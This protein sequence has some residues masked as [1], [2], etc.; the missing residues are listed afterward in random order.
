MW[1]VV[2]R[3]SQVRRA[4]PLLDRGSP[5]ARASF[6]LSAVP[7]TLCDAS[8]VLVDV[9]AAFERFVD[10]EAGALLGR[11]VRDL[12]H[13]TD[14]GEADDT[15]AALLAGDCDHAQDERVL[16]GPGGRPLPVLVSATALRAGRG[17]VLGAASIY[18]DLTL[19]RSLEQR[20]RQQE[21]F[22]LAM[23]RHASDL[24]LLLDLGGQVL[25]VSPTLTR[26]L[27]HAELD[28]LACSV[29]DFIHPDD[30]RAAQDAFRGTIVTGSPGTVTVRVRHAL[31][32]WRW[33]EGTITDLLHTSVGGVVCNLR[34]VTD[35]VRAEEALRASERRYRAMADHAD[36]GLWLTGPDGAT[37]YANRR[38]LDILGLPEEQVV[39]RS[40]L[41]VIEPSGP[42][43]ERR[44]VGYRHP[45][46]GLRT[47]LVVSTP[48]DDVDGAVE[49]SLTMVSDVTEARR[50]ERELRDSALHDGLTG[51]PNR[52]LLLDRLEHALLRETS[53]T[54]V[55][56]LDLD[57]F[58]AVNDR[59]GHAVGDQ[60]LVELARRIAGAV[61]A[62]Y[63]VARLGGDEIAVVSEE[64]DEAEARCLGEQ[65]LE[66][67]AQPVAT[68]AGPVGL[69]ASVGVA[70]T[71]VPPGESLLR[72]AETAMHAAKAAGRGRVE[73]YDAEQ[74][75]RARQ[76][77]ELGMELGRALAAD[78][79][80][81]HYQPVVDLFSGEV[82]GVEA[83]AR[84][85][86]PRLGAVP[87]SRFV[88]VAESEGLTAT[89]DRWALRRALGDAA[90]MR[91]CGVVPP[92]AY[93]AVN[94]SARSLG[95]PAL[96]ERIGSAL[97]ESELDAAD[98]V[99]E[100]TESATMADPRAAALVLE[101]LRTR[102]FGVAVDDFGTGHS[103]LAYLQRLPVTVL[104]LDRS[105]VSQITGD[106]DT[107]AITDTVVGLAR[108]MGLGVVAEGVETP[109]Q[110]AALRSLG[111]RSAQGWLWS[112]AV[113]PDEAGRTGV[114]R[115]VH[116]IPRAS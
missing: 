91:R 30:V 38:L 72:R 115:R 116:D 46:G 44:E 31:G 12:S 97:E 57:H 48:L 16:T 95:D 39:G 101:R 94:L 15:L 13:R 99:L 86:H 88:A 8:G 68:Q 81:L 19:L 32:T 29:A 83:L 102:G 42:L 90:E 78:E 74:A 3:R 1:Q 98:V 34:D 55:L 63:T 87:P 2:G 28:M 26:V 51:L 106:Q 6:Q 77:L 4:H 36:E 71:P 108:T 24:S 104:K 27:G 18:Q 54:A 84:W 58:G 41:E 110:L 47:L 49:G 25:F 107:R 103:S 37:A 43:G 93:V 56:V 70:L 92:T 20:R 80:E 53:T 66:V 113:P 75:D 10:R 100:V 17:R 89:L 109:E 62:S 76:R 33:M 61:P 9:N 35:R 64:V 73:V 40:M 112:A 111:V 65:L 7:Q 59:H 5:L 67:V 21:E 82:V 22:F 50:L 11:P 23:S 114:L 14:P 79:L 69:A 60:L 52:A 105:F 96:D 85:N 45:D